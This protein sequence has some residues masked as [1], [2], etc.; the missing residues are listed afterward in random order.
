MSGIF[1]WVCIRILDGGH[2]LFLDADTHARTTDL[3]L[4]SKRFVFFV[5]FS[6]LF[7][8]YEE[9]AHRKGKA[10]R[11]VNYKSCSEALCCFNKLTHCGCKALNKIN[12]L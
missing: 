6:S 12:L 3:A 11:V 10:H 8:Y 2:F 7:G 1:S 4:S 5:F 9:H